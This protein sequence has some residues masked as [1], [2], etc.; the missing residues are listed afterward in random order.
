MGP[1]VSDLRA[2]PTPRPELEDRLKGIVVRCTDGVELK[3]VAEMREGS[4]HRHAVKAT[5]RK[6]SGRDGNSVGKWLIN[7]GHQIQ[8]SSLAADVAN[9]PNDRVPKTLLHLQVVIVEVRCAEILA[10]RIGAEPLGV[11]RSSTI[12]IAAGQRRPENRASRIRGT[13]G[14]CGGSLHG[15]PVVGNVPT[16]I[17]PIGRN[18]FKSERIALNPL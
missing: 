10:D 3:D 18:G 6:Q 17:G 2:Q 4:C 8:L 5:Y 15:V 1:S 7:V 12:G 13:I 11:P 16:N 14:A 9:L